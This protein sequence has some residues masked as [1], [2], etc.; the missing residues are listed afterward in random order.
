MFVFA[1]LV[2]ITIQINGLI[3][4]AR[5]EIGFAKYGIVTFQSNQPVGL[6][7]YETQTFLTLLNSYQ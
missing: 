1:K 7:L 3:K 2:P 4:P 6:P 5:I